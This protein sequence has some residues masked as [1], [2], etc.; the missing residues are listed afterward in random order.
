M[1]ASDKGSS[2]SFSLDYRRNKPT[3]FII[4]ARIN[5]ERSLEEDLWRLRPGVPQRSAMRRAYTLA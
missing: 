1:N 4:D 3:R 2:T 5:I